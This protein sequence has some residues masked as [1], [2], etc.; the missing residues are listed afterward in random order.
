M[1]LCGVG[2]CGVG[3][4]GVVWCGVAWCGVAWCALV[5]GVGWNGDGVVGRAGRQGTWRREADWGAEANKH[6]HTH[7]RRALRALQ[8]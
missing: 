6:I 8:C 1:G 4:C 3:W 5:R 2:V 7:T